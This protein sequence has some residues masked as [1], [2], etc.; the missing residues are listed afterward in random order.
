MLAQNSVVSKL[1]FPDEPKPEK[2]TPVSTVDPKVIEELISAHREINQ[3][4]T[5]LNNL[6]QDFRERDQQLVQNTP[7]P[8][9][10]NV[11]VVELSQVIDAIN[12][13]N[14]NRLARELEAQR[15][16]LIREHMLKV[17]GEVLKVENK[18]KPVVNKIKELQAHLEQQKQVQEKEAPA[19]ILW[20]SCQALLD[21]MR[22]APQ[23]P[24]EKSPAYNV[25]REFAANNNQLAIAVLDS[26]PA[27][28]L[29]EGVQSEESLIDRFRRIDRICKRVAL[30]GDNGGGL[31]KYLVS[32]LQS[33]FIFDNVTVTEDEVSGR[34]LVDPTSWRTFDILA[35]VKYCL[36]RHN[37]EQALRYANQLRGQARVVARDW[38]R[39][40]RIHLETRQAIS[41]LSVHSEAI[42]VDA[43]R[44]AFVE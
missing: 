34:Q 23:E 14:S 21:K 9:T 33:L 12:L 36:D 26:I 25:L 11:D 19:R 27:K 43:V 5:N 29:K 42:A 37:L 41:V 13:S 31:A 32:Y 20:L 18:Y 7:R 1:L 10:S 28:A 4:K 35:R 22:Y 40:A 24:L 44:Q 6:K 16:L 15:K 3:L 8:S 2:V 38:I 30:V 17:E 39:D